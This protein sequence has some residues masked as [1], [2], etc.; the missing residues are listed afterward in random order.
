MSLP[1]TLKLTAALRGLLMNECP[2]QPPPEWFSGH[3]P[4]RTATAEPHLALTP[5]PFVGAE[6]ADGRILGLALVLPAELDHHE[7]GPCLEPF[8]PRSRHRLA[9]RTPVVRW[10][11]VRMRHRAGNPRAPAEEPR[12]G[13]LDAGIARLGERD[14]HSPEPALRRPGQVGG[15]AAESVKDMC[16]HI[17]LPRPREVLLHPVSLVEGAPHSREF[18]QLTRK[19]GGGRRSH[20]HAVIFFDE[21]VRGPVLLGAG[22][23]RGYGLCRPMDEQ[24]ERKPWLS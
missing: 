21:P 10:P 14:P 18:P 11:V 6:H 7:A 13:H 17:G 3:R 5:L 24:G 2:E 1:A 15:R 8:L 12:P 20:N 22:R 4:D 23:F 19:G 9:A 16:G